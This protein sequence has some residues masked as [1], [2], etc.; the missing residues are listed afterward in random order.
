MKTKSRLNRKVQLAFGSAIL[1]LLVVG[2]ISY[3]TLAR[4]GES[5]RWVRHT[6]EV[7]ANL[8][9]LL[10]AMESVES[11]CRGFA[12]T[13]EESYLDTYRASLLRAERDQTTIRSLTVDNAEQRRRLPALDALAAQELRRAEMLTSLRRTQG[14]EAA[15]EAV[16]GGAGQQ[17]MDEFQAM[18]RE[19]QDEELRLLALRDADAKRRITQART[20]LILGTVLGLLIA[21]AAGWA[22]QHDFAAREVAEEALRREEERFRDLANNISPTG[23]DGG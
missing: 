22:V 17:I 10:F 9:D 16:Q 6:H 11:S 2:T 20:V 7:L 15:A 3:H 8:Q 18:V 4:S 12:L 14:L 1:A 13:G 5:D 19:M 23:V 21:A